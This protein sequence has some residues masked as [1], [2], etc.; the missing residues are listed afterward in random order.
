MT[1]TEVVEEEKYEDEAPV[2][3]SAKF[4]MVKDQGEFGKNKRALSND[5][6]RNNSS[7]LSLPHN[8]FGKLDEDEDESGSSESDRMPGV[9]N[10]RKPNKQTY[11]IGYLTKKIWAKRIYSDDFDFDQESNKKIKGSVIM[12]I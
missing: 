5:F 7:R 12:S 10:Q 11:S 9:L 1:D 2:I 4:K 6:A 3:R 8:E